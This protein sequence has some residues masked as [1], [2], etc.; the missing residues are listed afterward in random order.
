MVSF[1]V[2]LTFYCKIGEFLPQH[3]LKIYKKKILN[4]LNTT[5]FNSPSPDL[6]K[7][8]IASDGEYCINFSKYLGGGGGEGRLCGPQN[9][10][11]TR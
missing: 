9:P 4:H 11:Y 3:L 10:S 6:D 5:P 7:I 1:E 2:P 8:S